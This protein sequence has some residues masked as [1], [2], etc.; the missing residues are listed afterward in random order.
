M[1]EEQ[2]ED[3]N[4]KLELFAGIS[5]PGLIAKSVFG[6]PEDIAR[7]AFDQAEAMMVESEKRKKVCTQE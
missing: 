2:I 3:Y 7:Q 6:H 4:S 1:N 5:L